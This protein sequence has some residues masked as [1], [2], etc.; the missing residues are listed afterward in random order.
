[1]PVGGTTDEVIFRVKVQDKELQ[2]GA[3]RITNNFKI[4]ANEIG[5]TNKHNKT[6]EF[7]WK[8]LIK[9]WEHL[10]SIGTKLVKDILGGIWKGLKKIGEIAWETGKNILQAFAQW[11][12][13]FVVAERTIGRTTERTGE[14]FDQL[15]ENIRHLGRT[16]L[17]GIIPMTELAEAAGILGQMGI[18]A[19]DDIEKLVIAAGRASVVTDLTTRTFAEGAGRLMKIFKVDIAETADFF[20]NVLDVF[21]NKIIGGQAKI[22]AMTESMAGTFAAAGFSWEETMMV[23]AAAIDA[24]EKKVGTAARNIGKI[25]N[26]MTKNVD[27]WAETLGIWAPEL[28]RLILENPYE[29]FVLMLGK[30]EELK[31][32]PEGIIALNKAFKTLHV[33]GVRVDDVFK[34]LIAAKDSFAKVSHLLKKE[35]EGENTAIKEFNVL[36]EKFHKQ[37][38]ALGTAVKGVGIAIGKW[39]GPVL[40]EFL[41]KYINP[42]LHSLAEWAEKSE[43]LKAL[44]ASLSDIL[45][46]HLGP[47]LEKIGK[48][49]ITWLKEIDEGI[50]TG[51]VDV[52]SFHQ[53]I[54][55]WGASWK[56][57]LVKIWDW[58]KKVRDT[59]KR[60]Y[61]EDWP[62]FRETIKETYNELKTFFQEIKAHFDEIKT[63]FTVL[64]TALGHF[65]G[66]IGE[67]IKKIKVLGKVSTGESV[68]PDMVE[69]AGKAATA[70]GD[71]DI[72]LSNVNTKL[73]HYENL[74]Q[75]AA[76]FLSAEGM[77]GVTRAARQTRQQQRTTEYTQLQAIPQA[78]SQPQVLEATLIMGDKEVGKLTGILSQSLKEQG[79]RQYAPSLG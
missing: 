8:D 62:V 15:G 31:K 9:T 52:V 55:D 75:K 12:E 25:F 21:G 65:T 23:A 50:R 19:A 69:W 53:A 38:Q 64:T 63:I 39:F 58:I 51:K 18:E 5:K 43:L 67:V 27:L 29:A 7:L 36:G 73:A 78:A 70:I 76:G 42:F 35:Q 16:T 30:M 66:N 72:A 49:L 11:E 17:Q 14:W 46:N 13:Q 1:M 71:I 79:D 3:V 68:F 40:A 74:M 60:W 26:E 22:L 2:R 4:L 37:L 77:I 28:K 54:L 59:L 45:M 6:G 33:S 41:Q 61:Q 10:I 47:W 24:G 20:L 32:T 44:S 57:W 48:G 34:K 56:N